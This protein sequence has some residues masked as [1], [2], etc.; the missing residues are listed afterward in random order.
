M[1][2]PF[3]IKAEIIIRMLYKHKYKLQYVVCQAYS[4][5]ITIK[6]H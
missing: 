6:M 4:K 5:Q 1:K 3:Y 2:R